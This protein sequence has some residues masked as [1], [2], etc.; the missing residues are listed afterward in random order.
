MMLLDRALKIRFIN[1]PA[2]G[3][4]QAD[5]LGRIIYEFVPEDQ[6]PQMLSCF[7]RVV[8]QRISDQYQTVFYL[9]DTGEVSFWES[10]VAPV[11]EED[12][13]TGFVVF[14]EDVTERRKT[15]LA[16]TRF[17][18]LSL[19]MMCIANRE[20]YFT[21]V[22]RAFCDTLGYT[23]EELLTR[24]FMDFVHE[25][26]HEATQQTFERLLGGENIVDFENQYRTK[27][28]GLRRMQ[29]RATF[30]PSTGMIF[31]VARDIT[32]Q[33][34]LEAQLRHSQKMDAVGQLAGGVAHDINN[35]MLAILCNTELARED[36]PQD[37]TTTLTYL[38]EIEDA[39]QRAADLT[40]DLL[41]FSRRREMLTSELQLNSLV[42]GLMSM[43][44]RLIPAHIEIDFVAG[45]RLGTIQG[46]AGQLEQIVVNLCLN[47]RD[48]M[49]TGGRLTIETENVLIN[50]RYRE[51]HPWAHPGRYVLL[52]I[53]D[54]GTGMTSEVQERAF[55]PFFTTKAVGQG[56]GLGLATVYGIV[57]Q[58]SGMVHIYSEPGEGTSVKVYLPVT[59]R[60]ASE[61]DS[62][63][64][65]SKTSSRGCVLVSED[66]TLVRNA[67]ER[68]LDRAGYEVIATPNGYE[69]LRLFRSDP[70][71]FTLVLLDIVT[72]ELGGLEAYERMLDIRTGF[73]VLFMSGYTEASRSSALGDLPILTKPF[74]PHV[75]LERI[76]E[77]L[78]GE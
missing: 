60:L 34:D 54:N 63:I 18:D 67:V 45:H 71:H 76:A 20:G 43:L 24:P 38:Q 21:S 39:C 69:A 46:D 15:E 59:S 7:E 74:K 65:K 40:R 14:S 44:Q 33:R 26:D 30:D 31:A 28:R 6:R 77:I 75:L 36:L 53:T 25:T 52:T 41:A 16:R 10:R 61:V 22:N 47:A 68:I 51:T 8:E 13:V 5:V 9:P 72:P 57:Q 48:A 3:L 19:D 42:H 62:K 78:K 4:T 66:E 70:E 32:Q 49:P 56:T 35:L 64:S 17:F 50:G 12:A 23:S 29:W 58:H 55:E 73:P 27:D 2:P 1:R 11:I 37:D